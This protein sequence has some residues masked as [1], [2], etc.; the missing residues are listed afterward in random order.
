MLSILSKYLPEKA[1][2]PC[3]ELIKNYGI[4]L[5]I[6]N[7]RQTRHG[8]YQL[9]PN[10]Q[11]KITI[12]ANLNKYR[13]LMTLIHEIA[14]LVTLLK[15]GSLVKPHGQEWKYTFQCLMTPFLRPEIFPV[16]LLPPLANHFRN[17]SASSDVDVPLSLA[18]REY[19]PEKRSDYYVFELPKG[20]FFRTNDGKIFQ[21]GNKI[22]KRY[23]CIEV[24]SKRK[25][26]I[27]PH[28]LVEW[29]SNFKNI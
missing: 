28:A 15:Y 22:I 1:V 3:F 11:H 6:V 19:D 12:N 21:K 10:G 14:H 4:Y 23:E 18:M 13:F 5:K 17:P 26:V 20:S 9:L 8:D 24:N 25:F 16:P 2:Q 29:L 27:Q 7:E